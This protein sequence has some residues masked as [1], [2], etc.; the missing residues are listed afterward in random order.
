MDV[1]PRPA[2]GGI[3][4]VTE[5]QVRQI[6]RGA[7]IVVQAIGGPNLALARDGISA[8]LA[9]RGVSAPEVTITVVDQL[10]RL[11]STGKVARFIAQA[12]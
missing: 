2:L 7:G 10:D 3:P 11:P 12:V 5:Y 4:E 9:R 6:A 8:G 1:H